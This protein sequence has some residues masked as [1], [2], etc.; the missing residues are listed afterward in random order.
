MDNNQYLKWIDELDK[1]SALIVPTR[2]LASTLKSQVAD[3]YISLAKTVWEAPNILTWGDYLR[4]LW[5]L[6]AVK[7]SPAHTLISSQ[8]SLLLWTQVVEASRR[9]ERDLT[10]LNVQQTAKAVQRSWR[11][12]HD[13][14]L[15]EKTLMQEHVEDVEQFLNWLSLSLIHI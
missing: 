13:W 14:R 11:L 4:W 6:N 5:Q 10:L 3:Y 15:S 12:M 2:S 9:L 7:L 1:T 8:Q